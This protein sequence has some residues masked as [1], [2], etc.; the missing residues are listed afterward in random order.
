MKLDILQGEMFLLEQ[1]GVHRA[2]RVRT[3]FIVEEE[4]MAGYREAR[5]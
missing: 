1:E 3:L 2:A 4:G 5:D